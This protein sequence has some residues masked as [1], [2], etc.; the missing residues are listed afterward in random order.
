[1]KIIININDENN[2][3]LYNGSSLIQ[4]EARDEFLSKIETNSA[5]SAFD[6]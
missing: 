2:T 5:Q 3:Q 6:F 4:I 1:M